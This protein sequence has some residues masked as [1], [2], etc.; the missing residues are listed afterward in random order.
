MHELDKNEKKKES[1]AR[2]VLQTR[3]DPTVPSVEEEQQKRIAA[4]A[5][6]AMAQVLQRRREPRSLMMW[7]DRKKVCFLFFIFFII[8]Y[9]YTVCVCVS[10]LK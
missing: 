1:R 9:I 5:A 2:P 10:F 4:R 3:T 8:I 6:T 7:G